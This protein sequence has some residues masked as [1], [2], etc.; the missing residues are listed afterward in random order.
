M[1]Y[2]HRFTVRA[3]VER[4]RAFHT[5]PDALASITPPPIRLQ[6]HEAPGSL[7]FG[8][9]LRF[10][11]RFGP[12]G[13]SWTARVE[14]VS[15]TGFVDVQESGPFRRWTHRHAFVALAQGQTEVHDVIDIQLRPHLWWGA[16]GLGMV[17][18]LPL[19]F[20]YRARRT[21]RLLE[22]A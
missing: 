13:V 14:D 10:T 15:P 16:F 1:I 19:L 3:P 9:R 17:L 5:R 22:A 18:G 6:L 12:L 11:L 2:R 7:E 20:A 21:R 8:G 4:V